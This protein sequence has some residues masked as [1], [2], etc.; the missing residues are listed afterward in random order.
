MDN[1]VHL[2]RALSRNAVAETQT[3]F[4]P[5]LIVLIDNAKQLLAI[6]RIGPHD[7]AGAGNKLCLAKVAGLVVIT[8]NCLHVAVLVDRHVSADFVRG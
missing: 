6:F 2:G 4:C 3:V 5:S 7:G 1:L 8:L